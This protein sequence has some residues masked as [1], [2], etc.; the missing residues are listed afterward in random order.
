MPSASEW[1]GSHRD[2]CGWGQVTLSPVGQGRGKRGVD[3]HFL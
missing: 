2:R 3:E 1:T